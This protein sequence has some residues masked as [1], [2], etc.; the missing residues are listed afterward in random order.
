MQSTPHRTTFD[1]AGVALAGNFWP[2]DES[3]TPEQGI[4]LFLHG[5]AQTRHSWR[6]TAARLAAAGWAAYT[7]DLR[8]HGDSEWAADGNYGVSAHLGDLQ[9]IIHTVRNIH[10]GLP[11]AIVGASLGGKVAL[12]GLGEDPDLA[13]I[14]VLV[15]I[16]VTVEPRGGSRVREFMKSAPA[17]FA[18]LEEAA[19]AVSAYKPGRPSAGNVEGLRKNLRL[20]DGRWYWHWDPAMLAPQDSTDPDAPVSEEIRQRA[21][22]AAQRITRPVLLVR[23][24]ASDVVSGAGVDE[25]R[26]LIPHLEVIDVREA[27]HMVTGDDNDMFTAGLGDFLTRAAADHGVLPKGTG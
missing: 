5:V 7:V 24:Q 22:A 20:R 10:P 14:L 13:D 4:A 16:A 27:G 11:V 12:I 19:E 25:M 6:R 2:V 9:K 23:G 26:R 18:S 3:D 1:G 8:G 15:D 17:G 21:S